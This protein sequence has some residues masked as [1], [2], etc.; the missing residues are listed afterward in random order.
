MAL[1]CWP[2]CS[3]RSGCCRHAAAARRE[4]GEI[5]AGPAHMLC[6]G[7]LLE[8]LQIAQSRGGTLQT[9]IPSTW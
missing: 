9:I 6:D 5:I 1:A 2:W 7:A 4:L 8:E 3:R